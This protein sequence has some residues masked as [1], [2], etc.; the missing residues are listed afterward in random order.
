MALTFDHAA[1]LIGVPQADAAPLLVQ[2]LVNAI[3]EEEASERG[4]A[5][6]QIADA[7]GKEALGSG[8]TT[9]ITLGLRSTWMLAFEAGA[10]QATVAGGNIADALARVQNTGSP[11]VVMQSSVATTLAASD[12]ST[13]PT[14]AQIAAAVW[15]Y[16]NRTLTG[17]PL[18]DVRRMN[19]ADVIGTG[20]IGDDW[21]GVGV[22]PG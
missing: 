22:P 15:A 2:V 7:S 17:M 8:V 10:Y 20:Q 13:G 12:G 1:K 5:H 14:E 9:G 6:D 18:V 11:Q 4:I 21:R 16:V 3:R 19:G